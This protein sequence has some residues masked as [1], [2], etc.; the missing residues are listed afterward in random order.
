MRSGWTTAVCEVRFAP[1]FEGEY[2]PA[3]AVQC[4]GLL[5]DLLSF[6]NVATQLVLQISRRF[7]SVAA[8]DYRRSIPEHGA[9]PGVFADR[10]FLTPDAPIGVYH[11]LPYIELPEAMAG[12]RCRV[13]CLV[14]DADVV[15]PGEIEVCHDSFD[16]VVVPSEF[17]RRAFQASGLRTP[18]LVVPHGVGLD[19]QPVPDRRPDVFTFYNVYDQIRDYRK[20][21]AELIRC[22]VK[23]FDRDPGI[24]LRLR[25]AMSGTLKAQLDEADAWEVVTVDA[26]PL[27]ELE[28]ARVFSE[29]HAT[30]HPSKA[31][32]FGMIPLQSL[33]CATPVIA[34]CT[35][36]MKDYLTPDNAMLLNT[37]GT[38]PA[39][40]DT[41]CDVGGQYHAIDEDHLVQCLRAM[42]DNWDEEAAKAVAAA[43]GIREQYNWAR[44]F[45]PLL[46]II[47]AQLAGSAV[48]GKTAS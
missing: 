20:S 11:G 5:G 31:E 42:H 8:H 44:V 10:S 15:P 34:P 2:N 47:A 36:G 17:C 46:D 32:G 43:P 18:V 48:A 14:C 29:V 35:T 41:G 39:L 38:V 23:A 13:G 9:G 12:H 16:L 3:V 27:P 25:T 1:R 7:E 22:F 33:S 40:G 4:Y 21:G 30:V 37:K 19:F 45:E 6:E 24:R 26:H 28:Y